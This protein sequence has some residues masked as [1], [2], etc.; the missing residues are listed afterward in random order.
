MVPPNGQL[1]YSLPNTLPKG[2]AEEEELKGCAHV[3][4]LSEM[5]D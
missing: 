2:T 5:G 1:V 4:S 3:L